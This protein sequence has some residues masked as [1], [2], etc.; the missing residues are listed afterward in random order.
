MSDSAAGAVQ[1]D[2]PATNAGGKT[3]REHRFQ[4]E[5]AVIAAIFS[6]VTSAI[7]VGGGV[8]IA[9]RASHA[10][11]VGTRVSY[12]RSER[13][14]AYAEI[15]GDTLQFDRD[16]SLAYRGGYAG[17]VVASLEHKNEAYDAL[18]NLRIAF[19]TMQVVAKDKVV[20]K[21]G[22]E[23]YNQTRHAAARLTINFRAWLIGNGAVYVPG[24]HHK[25]VNHQ[26]PALQKKTTL[27]GKVRSRLDTF[28]NVARAD[29]NTH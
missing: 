24:T 15:I 13:R 6:I 21:S 25:K 17:Y 5:L 4:L 7:G 2:V 27:L 12:L 14:A 28:T 18:N 9:N 22:L 23:D 11:A 8:I 10:E 19:A 16:A 29:L 26:F 20:L 1:A 3:R